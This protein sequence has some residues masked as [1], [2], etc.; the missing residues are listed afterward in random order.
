MRWLL[1]V[2]SWG[3]PTHTVDKVD[4][5]NPCVTYLYCVSQFDW[6]SSSFFT[7]ITLIVIRHK[8]RETGQKMK[9]KSL[10]SR[11]S[12]LESVRSVFLRLCAP[13]CDLRAPLCSLCSIQVVCILCS[14]KWEDSTYIGGTWVS[15]Y[16]LALV[17]HN[18][19][20]P[21]SSNSH[22]QPGID[23]SCMPKMH[24][25]SCQVFLTDNELPIPLSMFLLDFSGDSKACLCWSAC[26]LQ[27]LQP[28][29]SNIM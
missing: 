23:A 2:R 20:L 21:H 6:Y 18:L 11:W 15:L 13:F 22:V 24:G 5:L 14:S 19:L 8:K 3:N 4:Q 27:D 12:Y 28:P 25:C 26:W 10:Y 29:R 16:V 17:A 9:K 1:L 7:C